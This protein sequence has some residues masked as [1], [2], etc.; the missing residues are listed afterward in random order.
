MCW[1]FSEFIYQVNEESGNRRPVMITIKD[2]VIA[3]QKK[4][5]PAI[6][7]KEE[8]APP[9]DDDS[10]TDSKKTT[11]SEE[12]SKKEEGA[13]A[14]TEAVT[15]VAA[16]GPEVD[17]QPAPVTVAPEADE[18]MECEDGEETTASASTDMNNLDLTAVDG[19]TEAHQEA[20]IRWV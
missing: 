11:S 14:V 16:M 19:L 8:S 5:L 20:M 18:K 17:V 9:T 3:E 12:E 2:K 7:A 10:Q 13:E 1:T 6:M 15:L 4:K